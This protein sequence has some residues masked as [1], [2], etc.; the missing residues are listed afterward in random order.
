MPRAVLTARPMA[1]QSPGGTP[2]VR[3]EKVA[4]PYAA[5]NHLLARTPGYLASNTAMPCSG[6]R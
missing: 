3:P 6:S 4:S 1:S 5:V 2:L